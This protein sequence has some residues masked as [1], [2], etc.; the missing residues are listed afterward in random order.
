ME[1][2]RSRGRPV[3][4]L[5]YLKEFNQFWE[6]YGLK[7][8]KK[9]CEQKWKRLKLDDIKLILAHVPRYVMSTPD[10]KYRKHPKT[11]LHGECWN[12]E[13]ILSARDEQ[14]LKEESKLLSRTPG[15]K[16]EW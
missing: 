6:S 16:N 8:G 5:P 12:D 13:I 11:Y 14:I 1:E 15:F 9:I 4:T 2:K 7:T 3:A 10:I